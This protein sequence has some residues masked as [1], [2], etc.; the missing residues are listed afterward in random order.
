MTKLLKIVIITISLFA[1][2][3]IYTSSSSYAEE[4]KT[5]PIYLFYGEGCP[6][7]AKEKKFLELLKE[8]YKEQI[9][10]KEF[11][12]YYNQENAEIFASI[13]KSIDVAGVPFLIIGESYLAGYTDDETTGAAIEKEVAR[14]LTEE[15]PDS[16]KEFLSQPKTSE[17]I[18]YPTVI[19]QDDSSESTS[20][21]YL[22][23]HLFGE[24]NLKSVSLPIATILIAFVDG[25][26][27]CAMW[28]LIFLITMLIYMKD[29]KRLFILGSTFILISGLVYFIFL[30][31]WFNFF[32]LI[33]YVYW[34][35]VIIGL[36]AIFSGILH[37]KSALFDKGVCHVTN[38]KQRTSIINRTK[39][40]LSEKSFPLALFGVA[41]LAITVNLV[42]VVCSAGLPAIYTNLLSTI[43]LSTF[44]Y[45][46][47]LSL[48][49]F[50]FMLDDLLIF[51]I[52][53]KTF[54]VTGITQKYTKWVSLAG[55][56]IILIIG[57]ILII[58]PELLM[59]G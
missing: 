50:I 51:T 44:Q 12:V 58:K 25:F 35:K 48:Y 30:A 55:G 32:Q 45:Y 43:T 23:T 2:L 49:I 53:V 7:C 52:A 6:H 57:I 38:P 36:V 4:G 14:C 41:A 16:L 13:V 40:I 59:F 34:I 42:E 28:I 39:K 37:I 54:E 47:Y 33:G 8:K 46:L 15:C 11:E 9:S 20:P 17:I 1:F 22:N 24:I 10:V 19:S 56:I 18:S 5:V 26:N 27:P 3:G 29:K 31:A 21:L